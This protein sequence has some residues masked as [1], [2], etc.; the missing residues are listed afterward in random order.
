VEVVAGTIGRA[1]GHDRADEAVGGAVAGAVDRTLAFRADRMRAAE[2]RQDAHGRFTSV[3]SLFVRH[4]CTAD[5]SLID[6]RVVRF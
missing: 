2:D 3:E 5:A 4:V 1:V 6:R